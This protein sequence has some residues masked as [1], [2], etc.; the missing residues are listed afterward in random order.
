MICGVGRFC[1][2]RLTTPCLGPLSDPGRGLGR[3]GRQAA[4]RGAVLLQPPRPDVARGV[5]LLGVQLRVLRFRG[6]GGHPRERLRREQ[7]QHRD[8]MPGHGLQ[9][10]CRRHQRLFLALPAARHRLQLL[11]GDGARGPEGL[12]HL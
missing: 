2:A 6:P 12:L 8:S 5:R 7:R 4:L 1:L 10:C 9:R 3:R 11:A